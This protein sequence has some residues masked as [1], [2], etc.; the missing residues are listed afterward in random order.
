MITSCTSSLYHV[1]TLL[2]FVSWMDFILTFFF[3][4]CYCLYF[5]PQPVLFS[6]LFLCY[7]FFSNIDSKWMS[8]KGHKICFRAYW[9]C[10]NELS[11]NEHVW[12]KPCTCSHQNWMHVMLHKK[13]LLETFAMWCVVWFSKA[14]CKFI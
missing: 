12:N 14:T 3:W 8:M 2:F 13:V 5:L 9:V 1:Y 7:L 6:F 10:W 11:Q 4:N